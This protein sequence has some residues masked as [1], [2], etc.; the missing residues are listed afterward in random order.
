MTVWRNLESFLKTT[1]PHTGLKRLL[2]RQACIYLVTLL[3][4]S[5]GFPYSVTSWN[6]HPLK[7]AL[8]I[9]C[10]NRKCFGFC[11]SVYYINACAVLVNSF[12]PD[13]QLQN[14]CLK[15]IAPYEWQM[16]P[17][18]VCKPAESC[19]LIF[20]LSLFLLYHRHN[21]GL[22]FKGGCRWHSWCGWDQLATYQIS[23]SIG[24]FSCNETQIAFNMK[25]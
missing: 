21:S 15:V 17:V 22:K 4:I 7:G 2:F 12:F 16:W 10:H 18:L 20:V 11:S 1:V 9:V 24:L 19:V 13:T 25:D 6:E 8:E 14:P 5:T 23:V 3:W